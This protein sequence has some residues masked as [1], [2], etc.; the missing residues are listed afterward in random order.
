MPV[1]KASKPKKEAPPVE[2]P[3]FLHIPVS[4]AFLKRVNL[5]ATQKG[6]TI[7]E[8]VTNILEGAMSGLK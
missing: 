3:R 8:F 5:A 4:A 7:R 6:V 2:K 1:T